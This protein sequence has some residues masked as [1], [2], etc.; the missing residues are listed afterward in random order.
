M[1]VDVAQI[2]VNLENLGDII[3]AHP[4]LVT[5]PA[6]G[7]QLQFHGI[8]DVGAEELRKVV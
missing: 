5:C 6:Y 4:E 2:A 1:W 8:S 3:S 7:P